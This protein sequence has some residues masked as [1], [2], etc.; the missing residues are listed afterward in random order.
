MKSSLS[1]LTSSA[2]STLLIA[3]AVVACSNSSS[4]NS[5]SGA[6]CVPSACSLVK[7]TEISAAFGGTFS[8][9]ESDVTSS[10]L[11]CKYTS[12]GVA[13]VYV[14]VTCG[15]A[16]V[17]DSQLKTDLRGSATIVPVSG[18]GSAAEFGSPSDGTQAGAAY[19]LEVASGTRE[20]AINYFVSGKSSVDPLTATKAA[21]TAALGRM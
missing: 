3:C 16:P 9:S 2:V 13:S 18:L 11:Q 12:S 8:G 19:K 5:T 1:S 14:L 20:L 15:P 10:L 17:T 7:D 6:G 21:A 4:S